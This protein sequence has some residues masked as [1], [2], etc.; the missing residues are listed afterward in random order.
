MAMT[1]L[2]VEESK[3]NEKEIAFLKALLIQQLEEYTRRGEDAVSDMKEEDNFYPDPLD[4]ASSETDRNFSLRIK[5]RESR[6]I[7]KI[8]SALDRIEEGTYGI[9]ETCE[10]G[11]SFDRLKARP[12]AMHCI[13]CKTKSEHFEKLLKE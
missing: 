8:K 7:K 1:S 3:L 13:E 5:D 6:L 2:I 4:R 11:I 12:V 10:E 9:C